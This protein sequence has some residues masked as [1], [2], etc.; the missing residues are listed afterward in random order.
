[1]LRKAI[2]YIVSYARIECAVRTFKN[3]E[4]KQSMKFTVLKLKNTSNLN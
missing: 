2:I 3:A 1:M 4:V